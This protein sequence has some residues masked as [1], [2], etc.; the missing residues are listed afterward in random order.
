MCLLDIEESQDYSGSLVLCTI[1]AI[2]ATLIA[3]HDHAHAN[4]MPSVPV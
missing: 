2:F 4:N 3:V 1:Q